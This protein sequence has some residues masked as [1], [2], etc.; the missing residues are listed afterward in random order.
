MHLYGWT[1]LGLSRGS[2]FLKKI[3]KT[4]SFFLGRPNSFSSS[5]KSLKRPC[6]PSLLNHLDDPVLALF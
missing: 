4:L 3:A 2:G 1:D 6:F 5:L